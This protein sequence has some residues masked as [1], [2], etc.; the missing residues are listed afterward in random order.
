MNLRRSDLVYFWIPGW[1]SDRYL[2]ES[3]IH[4]HFRFREKSD[5]NMSYG[6][7]LMKEG[8]TVVSIEL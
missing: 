4:T 5:W 8:E 6:K 3:P 7:I 2:F 1:F